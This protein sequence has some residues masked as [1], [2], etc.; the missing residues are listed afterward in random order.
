MQQAII[1]YNNWGGAS[2]EAEK[3]WE[4][5]F[6]I[7]MPPC[8]VSVADEKRDLYVL[9][10]PLQ[11]ID[12]KWNL[13]TWNGDLLATQY[14]MVTEERHWMNTVRVLVNHDAKRKG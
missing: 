11:L 6:E 9:R 12:E 8:K 13:K 3:K 4:V 10:G 14:F 2:A 1:K 5:Y 7:L